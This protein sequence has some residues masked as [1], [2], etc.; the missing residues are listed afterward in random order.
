[1]I[2]CRQ[3][4]GNPSTENTH[5][6]FI[7]SFL[8]G[9]GEIQDVEVF[10]EAFRQFSSAPGGWR[11][12][13]DSDNV[14]S[15]FEPFFFGSFLHAFHADHLTDKFYRWLSL[16]G[17]LQRHVDVIYHEYSLRLGGDWGNNSP[18]AC[19]FKGVFNLLLSNCT[20]CFC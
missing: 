4:L 20:L 16:L 6:Y 3:V 13:T 2:L 9:F 15:Y 10:T 8:T 14:S 7:K 11:G 19:S 12:H 1:V 5:K 18:L 17:L